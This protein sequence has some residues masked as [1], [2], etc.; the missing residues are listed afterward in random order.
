MK[1]WQNKYMYNILTFL[2]K[3]I[4]VLGR[5]WAFWERSVH[6][7]D[8]LRTLNLEVKNVKASTDRRWRTNL[9]LTSR[10]KEEPDLLGVLAERTVTYKHSIRR[11]VRAVNCTSTPLTGSHLT[12]TQAWRAEGDVLMKVV[13]APAS[14]GRS[15]WRTDSHSA[16]LGLATAGSH[17]D[18]SSTFIGK[19]CWAWTSAQTKSVTITWRSWLRWWSPACHWRDRN[20]FPASKSNATWRLSSEIGH[21]ANIS[22]KSLPGNTN[23]SS[24]SIKVDSFRKSFLTVWMC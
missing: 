19:K 6:R 14:L 16:Y 9:F 3:N 2:C 1:Y 24:L 12:G 10:S 7:L 15:Q 4:L 21:A 13:R 5:I 22:I 18:Q 17:T 11:L 20:C 8:C 23:T